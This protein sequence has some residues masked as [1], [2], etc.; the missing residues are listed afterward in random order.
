[1]RNRIPVH[2]FGWFC[3]SIMLLA[4]APHTSALKG[5]SAALPEATAIPQTPLDAY[6]I[7]PLPDWSDK[8]THTDHGADVRFFR[9]KK[10]MNDFHLSRF[11]AVDLQNHYRHLTATG[12]S[13]ALAFE[14]ALAEV[15]EMC[16]RDSLW[17][18]TWARLPKRL[19]AV[20]RWPLCPMRL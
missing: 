19:V 9:I 2:R 5:A 10:L 4:C 12:I 3:L 1:M 14:R 6:T 8:Y 15:R 7:P 20:I 13:S 17:I 16:I 11:Q 18:V